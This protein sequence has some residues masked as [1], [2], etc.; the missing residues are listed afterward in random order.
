MV[1]QNVEEARRLAGR[2]LARLPISADTELT[3]LDEHTIEEDFGWLFFWTSKKYRETGEFKYAL[4]GNAPIIVDRRD[5]SVHETST[6]DCI[7]D[8]I[9]HYKVAHATVQ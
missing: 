7:D 5:S 8:I 6:A 4:A 1:V 3:I 9:D 2:H